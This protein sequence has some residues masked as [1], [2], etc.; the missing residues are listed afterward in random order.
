[1]LE[2]EDFVY[3]DVQ[4]T[5]STTIRRFL[6]RFARTEVVTDHKHRPV[7][8]RDPDK[9]YIISCRDPLKQ[10]LSLYSHGNEGKGGLRGRLNKAG[11]SHFYNGTNEGFTSWLELLLDPVASQK[12]L[13]G[14]DNHRI[15]DFVGLQTLRFLILAFASPLEVFETLR[16]KNDVKERLRSAGLYK[17]VIK[18]ESLSGDLKKLV[19]GEHSA[20]FKRRSAATAFL[21]KDRTK[22][23]SINPGIDLKNLPSDLVS[24]VQERDW[25]YFEELGYQPYVS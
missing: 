4:K 3:L 22:N 5:G 6:K 16:D 24:R 8:R 21:D 2:F 13:L 19:T 25:L 7:E 1:M 18:T 12:H 15:L 10:Y 20:L 9:L 23:V 17:V 11:M 14:V